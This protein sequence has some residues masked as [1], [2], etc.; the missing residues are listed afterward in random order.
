VNLAALRVDA[1]HH[2]LNGAVLAG[3]VH[4]LE[5]QQDA[6]PILRVELFLQGGQ[7][8]RPFL[9][10]RLG[11]VFHVGRQAAGVGGVDV[12]EPERTA[13]GDEIRLQEVSMSHSAF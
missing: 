13:V 5:D 6:P 7:P 10:H 9:Q 4:R 8:L 12:T 3:R 1:R 11:P 2:V